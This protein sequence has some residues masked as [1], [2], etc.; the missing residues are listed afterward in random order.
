M[1][2]GHRLPKRDI[3]PT[4]VGEPATGGQDPGHDRGGFLSLRARWLLLGVSVLVLIAGVVQLATGPERTPSTKDE[5][6]QVSRSSNWLEVGYFV[7]DYLV[8]T[9]FDN[10]YVYGPAFAAVAHSFNA[11]AGNEEWGRVTAATD[12]ITGRHLV[13]AALALLAALACGLAVWFATGSR[14]F[15]LWTAAALLS[16]PIWTGM[17]FFNPKDTPAATGY[18]LFT[19]GLALALKPGGRGLRPDSHDGLTALLVATGFFL[20]VGTRLALWPALLASLLVFATLLALRGRDAVNRGRWPA[21]VVGLIVGLG[22]LI[23]LYPVVFRQPIELLSDSISGSSEYP[24]A[25]LTLTA[26]QL[27]SENPP[28][29]YLPV[30]VFASTPVLI[31]ALALCGTVWSVVLGWRSHRNTQGVQSVSSDPRLGLAALAL[32]QLLLVPIASIV[33]GSTMYT[34]MR[35]HLYIAPAIAMISGLGVSYLLSQRSV[36]MHSAPW[37]GWLATGLVS[38]AVI[39]PMTEQ[40][41][42]FPY[43]YIYVNPVAGIGGVDDRWEGDYWWASAKEASDRVPEGE[44]AFCGDTGPGQEFDP[45]GLSACSPVFRPYPAAREPDSAELVRPGERW[46]LLRR[47]SGGRLPPACEPAGNV[48]RWLRGE[49]L[50]ISYVARC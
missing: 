3:P 29:W 47:R 20:A 13:S 18:T 42:L 5:P 11:L 1:P 26:G 2:W 33:T 49:T 14:A 24:W 9:K 48:T 15:G 7:P 43:N 27:L 38:L 45:R 22:A 8:G 17:G 10:P 35:Q 6:T 39:A 30:W 40:M 31:G 50:V 23:A 21:V 44:T 16:I 12:A 4:G 36:V 28:W 46:T 19:V 37:R 32:T 25:G 41:I 34:G